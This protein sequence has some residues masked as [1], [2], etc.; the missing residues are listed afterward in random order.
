MLPEGFPFD[1][2]W[3]WLKAIQFGEEAVKKSE[4]Y[5]QNQ[6][7]AQ[8]FGFESA[9]RAS[10][11]AELDKLGVSPD[12][13]L[14]GLKK[15]DLPDKAS[16][17]PERRAGK[18]AD[19]TRSTPEKTCETRERTVDPDYGGAQGDARTYLKHQY[20]NDDGVMF[21]QLCQDSQPVILNGEPHFE[22]VDCVSCISFHYEQNNLALCPNHAAM[23]KNGGLAPDALQRAILEC[24]GQKILLNLAGN[25]VELYF[26]QQHLSDLRAILANVCSGR[27]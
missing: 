27:D 11:W 24:E 4:V 20:T 3:Q 6:S 2:G 26:T 17:N 19:E 15:R 10:K 13:L 1:P 7:S 22:A 12:E 16:P 8:A 21:C 9:D 14:A 25:E 23:Y 18:I 5:R